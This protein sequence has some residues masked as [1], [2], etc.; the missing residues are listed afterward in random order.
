RMDGAERGQ[1]EHQDDGRRRPQRRHDSSRLHGHRWRQMSGGLVVVVDGG[2]RWVLADEG[3]GMGVGYWG[4]SCTGGATTP[5]RT[6]GGGEAAGPG[7][8]GGWALPHDVRTIPRGPSCTTEAAPCQA[9]HVARP[10]RNTEA[11]SGA[12]ATMRSRMQGR[13]SWRVQVT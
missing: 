13:P 10:L 2:G 4:D 6:V 3:L 7:G 12:V 5:G 8:P 1:I 9:A 11:W